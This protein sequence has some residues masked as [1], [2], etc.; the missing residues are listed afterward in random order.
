MEQ[1]QLL[2]L[3]LFVLTRQITVHAK[4]ASPP[5]S[6]QYKVWLIDNSGEQSRNIEADVRTAVTLL[7]YSTTQAID[8]TTR[9]SRSLS[10]RGIIRY[11]HR[12]P[13]HHRQP[14]Q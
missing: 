4:L 3:S 13:R 12:L 10:A 9:A 6:T 7:L 2:Q 11:C 8:E 14:D 1:G 5:E